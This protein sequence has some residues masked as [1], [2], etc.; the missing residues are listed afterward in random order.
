HHLLA[1]FG[2]G[3]RRL[4]RRCGSWLFR[5]RLGLRRGLDRPCDPLLHDAD[6]PRLPVL[7]GVHPHPSAWSDRRR[8]P[9]Q[10]GR[11]R[12]PRM[13]PPARLGG[14]RGR[15]RRLDPDPPAARGA[16][17]RSGGSARLKFV[18]AFAV[19]VLAGVAAPAVA[20]PPY[21]TDDP[22]PPD[23]SHWEI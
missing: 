22:V 8:L 12:R 2:H 10:A 4:D 19:L 5:R 11:E 6:Q 16:A 13:E 20:G 14:P 9:R 17:P 18:R 7:G 21:L 23:T 3:A 15:H 1:N